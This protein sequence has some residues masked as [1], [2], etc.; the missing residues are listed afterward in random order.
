M[1]SSTMMTILPHRIK[2]TTFLDNMKN[3]IELASGIPSFALWDPL[4]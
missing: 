2:T 4:K 1:Q 3:P